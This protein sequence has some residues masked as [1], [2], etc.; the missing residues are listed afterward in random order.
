L[1]IAADLRRR[2]ESREFAE[3]TRFLTETCL[4]QEYD[5]SRNTVRDAIKLLVQQ[6]LLE[7]RG[8]R[9]TFITEEIVPFV[10]ALSTD[11]RAEPSGD[12]GATYTAAVHEQSREAG[13]GPLAVQIIKCPSQIAARL[14]I[15]E[16][17]RVVSRHQERFIDGTAWSSKTSYYPLEWVQRGA[18]G[19]LDPENIPEGIVGYLADAIGFKQVGHRDLISARLANDREQE[20]FNLTHSHSVIEVHRTSF[21]EDGTPIRVTVTVFPSDRNRLSYDR[22]AVPECGQEPAQL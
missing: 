3:G 16:N 14:Q 6:R 22:G 21:A 12:E 17:D 7:A 9:G 10:T 11:P 13:A 18:G 20:L 8:G 19:L 2:I 15:G 1:Q 5:A 4:Q